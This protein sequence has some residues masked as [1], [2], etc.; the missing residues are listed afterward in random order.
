M[1]SIPTAPTISLIQQERLDQAG[2]YRT[3][4]EKNVEGTK[5]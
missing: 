5:S 1:G 2:R 3:A 4:I